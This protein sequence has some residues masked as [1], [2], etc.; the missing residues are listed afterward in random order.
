[1]LWTKAELKGVF[2]LDSDATGVSIDTRSLNPGDL[3]F[4]VMGKNGVNGMRFAHKARD[5]GAAGVIEGLENLE[6]LGQMARD[7]SQ[8]KRIAVTG[9][10]GKTSTKEMLKIAFEAFGQTHASEGSYNN[11]WGVPLSLARTP[12][13]TN[14]GIFEM[15][16][17]R[18]GELRDLGK[19]VCPHIGLITWI[20]PAHIEF[21]DSLEG[22]ADAKSE[23]FEHMAES[24]TAVLPSDSSHFERLL[25]KAKSCDIQNIVT[26]GR[27]ESADIR[28]LDIQNDNDHMIV[29]VS[30]DNNTF[31]FQLNILGDH[32][33]MNAL[34]VLGC[35]MA[36]GLD[37]KAAA[38]ALSKF[39]P[40][41]RRGQVIDTNQGFKI[42][43]ESYNANPVSMEAAIKAFDA[44]PSKRRK[45]AVL[46]DMGELGRQ[47]EVMHRG[48]KEPLLNTSIDHVITCGPLMHHL[49]EALGGDMSAQ[50]FDDIDALIDDASDL[51]EQDDAILV[52]GSNY[53]GL[54]RLVEHL[55]S[56]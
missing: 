40:A 17:N 33:A 41:I 28:L 30:Q 9:S 53:M 23:I 3:F 55:Q 19:Q 11:Q 32:H 12:R 10:V 39:K 26:F 16:M 38:E 7:R 20:A 36:C 22:I 37:V 44:L 5:N 8:A 2:D 6:K 25:E 31:D 24:S 45:V 49:Y 34:G 54:N 18:A 1:M 15:G 52:K 4:G 21:F 13:D 43:D 48:L 50:H 35:V 51:F 56:A 42:I 29:T 47:A 27:A 46:G 14:Y